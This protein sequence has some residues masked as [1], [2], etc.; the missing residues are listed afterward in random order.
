MKLPIRNYFPT[1]LT[2]FIEP[3]C[4]EFEIVPGG[5]AKITLEDGPPHSIDIHPDNWISI[6]NEGRELAKVELYDRDPSEFVRK[7]VK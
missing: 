2:I 6:W 5:K 1:P 7:D 4:D 3:Y